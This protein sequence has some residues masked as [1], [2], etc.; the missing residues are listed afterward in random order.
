MTTARASCSGSSSVGAPGPRR[1]RR[2]RAQR[3]PRCAV[4]IR[5]PCRCRAPDASRR[6]RG[7]WVRPGAEVV[8]LGAAEPC[9]AVGDPCTRGVDLKHRDEPVPPSSS[10]GAPT[11]AIEP[12]STQAS[13]IGASAGSSSRPGRRPS[14]TPSGTVRERRPAAPE[15]RGRRPRE[16]AHCRPRQ[17]RCTRA[18]PR[19]SSVDHAPRHLDAHGAADGQRSPV[20]SRR[21]TRVVAR[22]RAQVSGRVPRVDDALDLGVTE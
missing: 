9:L 4:R 12:V 13:T 21:A 18:E 20:E 19:R 1:R 16:P 6:P 2:C 5:C 11:S 3:C 10:I 7:P 8:G 14:R 22:R 17:R 15:R